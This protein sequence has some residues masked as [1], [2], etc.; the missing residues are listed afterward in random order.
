MSNIE[1]KISSLLNPKLRS[2]RNI[3]VVEKNNGSYKKTQ[4]VPPHHVHPSI[5]ELPSVSS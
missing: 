1:A 3:A 2:S 5:Q 4:F